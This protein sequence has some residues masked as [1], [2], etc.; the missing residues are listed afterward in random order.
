MN[1][2]MEHVIL[3]PASS[4]ENADLTVADAVWIGVALLQQRSGDIRPFSTETI[5]NS[6]VDLHLTKGAPK[7][8]WQHVN[9]HCVANRKPQPNRACMLYATGQGNRRL[10]RDSD[11]R[12]PER[13]GGRTHPD[14]DKLPQK[15]AFL[16]HWY[17]TIWN[18]APA[19]PLSDPLLDLAGTGRDMWGHQS[20]DAYVASLREGWES[21]A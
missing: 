3:E 20:A 16:Q 14:W 11:R 18:I 2:T 8:I 13:E 12:D 5:V 15:Y 7:S 9:Q 6:I 21:F 10:Y 17:E 1:T 19:I 4:S